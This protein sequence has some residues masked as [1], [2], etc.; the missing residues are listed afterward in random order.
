MSH[1]IPVITTRNTHWI[2]I[3]DKKAGW[4]IDPEVNSIVNCLK[5]LF[6]MDKEKLNSIGE[7]GYNFVKSSYN[8]E[9]IGLELYKSYEQLF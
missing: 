4:L 5:I 3:E 1:K 6:K 9:K 8:W 7:N 2:Q